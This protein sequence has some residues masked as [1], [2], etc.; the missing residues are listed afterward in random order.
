MVITTLT[1]EMVS[2][3][4]YQLYSLQKQLYLMKQK[5]VHPNRH[6]EK[7]HLIYC[8]SACNSLLLICT[9]FATEPIWHFPLKIAVGSICNLP[10]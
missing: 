3:S 9:M 4:I 1:V 2:A 7:D 8:A 6:T 10:A 5:F